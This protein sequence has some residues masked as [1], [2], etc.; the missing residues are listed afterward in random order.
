MTCHEHWQASA[1]DVGRYA[2][3]LICYLLLTAVT[4]VTVL[5]IFLL[6]C[7]L[8]ISNCL[9]SMAQSQG[10]QNPSSTISKQYDTE[11][12]GEQREVEMQNF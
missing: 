1:A 12:D 9:L 3:N 5:P 7:L 2:R 6:R 8:T 11:D 4:A 10:S